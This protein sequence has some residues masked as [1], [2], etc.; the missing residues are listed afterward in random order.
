MPG[1]EF[2]CADAGMT[3]CFFQVQGAATEDEVL[4]IAA[5][6][7]KSTHNI[8]TVSPEL[9]AKVKGAIRKK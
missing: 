4:K 8:E 3:G 6:H 5:V 7:A 9:A 1:Y 2:K